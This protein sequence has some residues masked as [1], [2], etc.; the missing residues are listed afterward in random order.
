M[1]LRRFYGCLC[2]EVAQAVNG[3]DNINN[4]LIAGHC[5]SAPHTA[6]FDTVNLRIKTDTEHLK[7]RGKELRVGSISISLERQIPTWLVGDGIN[8]T[9]VELANWAKNF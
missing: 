3:G 1:S 4:N 6:D 2:Q 5:A 9:E 8:R 7:P